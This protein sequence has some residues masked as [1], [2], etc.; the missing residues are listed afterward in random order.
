[1]P[2]QDLGIDLRYPFLKFIDL[3]GEEH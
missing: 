2:S 1:M 3:F